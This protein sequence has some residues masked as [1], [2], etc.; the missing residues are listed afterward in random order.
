MRTPISAAKPGF[1]PTSLVTTS[2]TLP[3]LQTLNSDLS[4]IDPRA[5][6]YNNRIHKDIATLS[7][8]SLR[9]T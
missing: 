3:P 4:I 8:A 6:E 5:K 9:F 2:K 1:T 7:R